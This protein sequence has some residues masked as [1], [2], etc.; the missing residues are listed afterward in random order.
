[1][2]ELLIPGIRTDR[3]RALAAIA[4]A[5]TWPGSSARAAE[6]PSPFE[7]AGRMSAGTAL[8]AD[9]CI[10][11]AGA[12]GITL[13]RS[14]AGSGLEVLLLEAGGPGIEGRDQALCRWRQSGQP[15]TD[16]AA[17]RLRYFGGTTNHWAGYS[18][19]P[20]PVDFEPRPDL[21]LPGWP[22]PYADLAPYFASAAHGLGYPDAAFD[23]VLAA[24]A[25]GESAEAVFDAR[26]PALKTCLFR[27]ARRQRLG[28]RHAD[29]L[30]AQRGLRVVLR[31]NVVH[32]QLDGAGR[33][34]REAH[35]RSFDGP[36]LRVR[37]RRWVLAAHALENA[38]LLLVSNDLAR[39]GI[40]NAHG[41]VG[42]GFMEHPCMTSGLLLPTGRLPRIYDEQWATVHDMNWTV[43]LS[44]V[45]AR[46]HG[47]LQ[48]QCRLMPVFAHD[49]VRLAVRRLREAWWQPGSAQ[50]LADLGEL[51]AHPGDVAGLAARSLADLRFKPLGYRLEHRIEQAPDP[52]SRVVL[53]GGRDALGMPTAQLHWALSAIDERGFA[54]G[55]SVLARELERLGVG[56]V[57]APA[58]TP[59]T[60]RARV[61][62]GL[63]HHAG[64]ARMSADP[65]S[66]VVDGDCRVHGTDNLYVAG[67]AVFPR[68][69]VANPTLTIV[70]L[71]LR[72]ADH[73]RREGRA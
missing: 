35:V 63:N 33:A 10:V 24:R 56:Q 7:D 4:T 73:L 68:I 5:L 51:A 3:R 27:I 65:R 20:Q 62:E 46:H 36:P 37:A 18:T 45:Q 39:A 48:Y 25:V 66:G 42:R 59:A 57:R 15:Y 41:Q 21:G 60:V 31:A 53:D 17:C 29:A 38:R 22:V 19:A 6:L 12:A 50:A 1:M 11:G 32:L 71:A 58:L 30:A 2:A 67:S 14:L 44:D 52:A 64:T 70:A 13:A 23:P 55:Q 69:G 54:A 28:E 34:V 49:R 8:E 16:L 26:S 61:V 43:G 72:L 9:I 40:G 47:T